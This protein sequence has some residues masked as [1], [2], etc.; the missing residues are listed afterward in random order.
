MYVFACVRIFSSFS[1]TSSS[2]AIFF[3]TDL[4]LSL[5]DMELRLR[6]NKKMKMIERM[7]KTEKNYKTENGI[8]RQTLSSTT[9]V[10]RWTLDGPI[11]F[12]FFQILY[13]AFIVS[14]LHSLVPFNFINK[15]KMKWNCENEVFRMRKFGITNYRCGLWKV[16]YIHMT[17]YMKGTKNKKSLVLYLHVLMWKKTDVLPAY[18]NEKKRI[19]VTWSYVWT[20]YHVHTISSLDCNEVSLIN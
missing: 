16:K 3:F 12:P 18:E 10:K 4:P 2:S 19:D 1:I 7:K 5:H 13:F 17:N 15:N 9:Q 8:K 11:H 14:I 6:V 20:V